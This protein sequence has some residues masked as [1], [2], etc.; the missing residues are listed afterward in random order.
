MIGRIRG[1]P[2]LAAL[3]LC[4]GLLCPQTM[5]SA[6]P[7][8]ELT[9]A[10]EPVETVFTAEPEIPD[11]S[12]ELPAEETDGA[13][14][15]VEPDTAED[16]DTETCVEAE[17]PLQLDGAAVS[18]A[19]P[20][21]DVSAGAWYYES[22]SYVYYNRL[23]NGV[24]GSVFQPNGTMTRAM[25]VT[26]LWRMAGSPTPGSGCAFT[27]LTQAWYRSAV[28]WAWDKGIAKG[29]T[30][31]A[32]QPDA[33]VTR[34]QIA[35]FIARYALYVD[36][37]D[38]GSGSD[39]SA[40]P[41]ESTVSAFARPAM[42]WANAVGLI[43]GSDNGGTVLLEPRGSATRGQVAAILMRY[44]QS[45][46]SAGAG[47]GIAELV[48]ASRTAGKTNQILTVV[49]HDLTFWERGDDG[50][51]RKILSAYAGYGSNGLSADRREGDKTTPIG[52]FPLLY[53]FGRDT[54]PGTDMA[55]RQ[56][57]PYSYY[58]ADTGDGTYNTWV[59]SSR[60]VIGEHL[61][62]YADLQ[63]RYGIVI[64]FNTD[65]VTVG[66][67]SAIFLH[68]KGNSWYTDGCVSVERSV[69]LDILNRVNDGAWIIVVKNTQDLKN[70]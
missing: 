5:A 30:D 39:L 1:L 53:A 18:N 11:G 66:R 24:G 43:R 7:E 55:Y 8:T 17:E 19:F 2:F 62:D 47:A 15:A 69:M 29:V 27:D 28:A 12:E 14:A 59:E 48:A 52:A 3:I 32:F 6:E 25:V 36:G 57:T 21:T 23:M 51:W 49:N 26:V 35:A 61:A 34:E 54:N 20:F 46:H 42:A 9:A 13:V 60:K 16:A 56:I 63:Y 41:D 67:G 40:F 10:E 38:T 64:G 4:F 50:V 65:P 22:V 68:C 44:R 37:L 33:P 31:T 45:F 58:S 70:Y